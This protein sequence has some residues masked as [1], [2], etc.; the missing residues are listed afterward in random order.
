MKEGKPRANLKKNK[1]RIG[2]NANMTWQGWVFQFERANTLV[3]RACKEFYWI[4]STFRGL[5]RI[6]M[7]KWHR[8]SPPPA[9]SSRHLRAMLIFEY[10]EKIHC[11]F[12]AREKQKSKFNKYR[13][14]PLHWIDSQSSAN[15][16]LICENKNKN[17]NMIESHQCCLKSTK[18]FVRPSSDRACC[19]YSIK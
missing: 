9:R 8:F 10:L 19:F 14:P 7:N 3:E 18:Q 15:H 2:M 13:V 11:V 16:I 5:S 6:N 17:L 1:K 4:R 12:H